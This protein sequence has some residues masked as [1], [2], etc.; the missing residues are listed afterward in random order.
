MDPRTA[1]A[2]AATAHGASLSLTV[3]IC[4]HNRAE[5]LARTLASLNAATRPD[6]CAIEVLVVANA[7]NDRTAAVLDE[8]VA[9]AGSAGRLPLRWVH[10]LQPGKSYALNRAIPMIRSELVAFVDDDHRVDDGYLA[11]ICRA[12]S[13]YPDA[14]LFCGR[15]LPDWDGS[16]PGWVHD[17]GPYRIYPLPIPRSDLGPEPQQL[18]ID[19]PLLPGGG[20]LFLR[21]GVFDRVGEFSVELG[22]HGHDLGGGE[23]SDFVTRCLEGGERLQYVPWVTQHHYVDTIRLRLPYLLRKGFQRSRSGIN[24]QV[25]SARTIPLYMWRKLAS[26]LVLAVFTF[27]WARARF[28]L[29]R[30]AAAF[31]ELRGF[32]DKLQAT[33]PPGHIR[34]HR[35]DRGHLTLWAAFPL[36]ALALV[37]LTIHQQTYILSA[38]AF[39]TALLCTAGLMCK[40]FYDFSQTGPQLKAE[41]LRHYRGYS[42]LALLRLGFWAFVLCAVMA[43]IGVVLYAAAVSM[44]GAPLSV[45]AASSAAL[46]GI[47]LL[48][49]LQFCRH[50][51][52]VPG[53]VAASY[54]YR[55]SRLYPLWRRLTPRRL[56]V[57]QAL[58]G[59]SA[60][61]LTASCAWSLAREGDAVLAIAFGSLAA[62]GLLALAGLSRVAV[63]PVPARAQSSKP[64]VLMIGSDTL[65]A[66][67]LGVAGYRRNLTPFID[68]LAAKGC[69]FTA[70]YVPCA[71]TA[72]S[73]ISMLTG[74]WPHHHGIRDNFVGD[75]DTGLSIP[76]LA[77][78]LSEQGYCT[79]A[80]SDWSGADLGKFPLGFEIRDL[81][82]DQWNIKYL[83]RQGPKDLRLFLSLF[84]RN[85]FG[86]KFLPELYYLAGVPLT[87]LVGDDSRRL[88][89]RF[90]SGAGP[91]FL[92]VFIS[93]THPPFGSEYPYYTLYRNP[94]YGGESR[95]VMDRL[96]DP[97]EIIRRQGDSRKEFDLDQI[98]DLYD[99]CVRNF[100]DEVKSII[101]H[102][103]ACRLEDNTIVVIYSDHGMEFFEHDT[104]GQGNSVRGDSS[105]RIPLVIV[106]P[107]LKQPTTCRKI[108]RSI[109]VAPTLL[110]LVGLSAPSTMDG[111]SLTPYLRGDETKDLNLPAFNETGIWL[112]DLPGM[113]AS[114]LRYPGLLDL[115]EVPDK[116]TGTLSVAPQYRQAINDAKDRMIRLGPW[117]LT[118]QPTTDGALYALYNVEDDP[119]CHWNQAARHPG[120]VADLRR[121]LL[122]WMR[123]NG[124]ELRAADAITPASHPRVTAA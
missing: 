3:L 86:K 115:L 30:L 11:G 4:T 120:I 21:R 42:I 65:R 27:S 93:T 85:R 10:E 35:V 64:N 58:L 50:L 39:G 7:C 124:G 88:I 61:I 24:L 51:L 102:L 90:A 97:W 43:W 38:A 37:T 81:P 83:L 70:C 104:W 20:N 49:L 2:E 46:G 41:I 123:G 103:R 92:N 72:P 14:T 28:Y 101:E 22:P 13:T 112:T 94:D 87:S 52:F 45:A 76:A 96:T 59:A 15:I 109:D 23:D 34:G 60:V 107:R 48:T 63:G 67:R 114:H 100:D 77:S 18:S 36:F 53:S 8:Y 66:D 108:V 26:Y 110:D 55:K 47:V 31:G 29:V 12:A 80:V 118:Y 54:H 25:P 6:D 1:I 95:F 19:G 82:D 71:R 117:K 105:A 78:L 16:E 74:T 111:T 106:D 119:E 122:E 75:Q 84:T 5:L 73:L 116:E 33:S 40:S 44:L 99:G 98:I 89:S 91:F 62:A 32:V 9:T 57:A 69:Q 68:A 121:R 56:A 79:A 17:T 113:P